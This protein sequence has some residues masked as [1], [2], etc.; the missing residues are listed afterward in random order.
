MGHSGDLEN[1]RTS[2]VSMKHTK[3]TFESLDNTEH[4]FC[5]MCGIID[6]HKTVT[7]PCPPWDSQ[8]RGDIKAKRVYEVEVV[9]QLKKM[10]AD[11]FDYISEETPP[12]EI[13]KY[14]FYLIDK[15]IQKLEDQAGE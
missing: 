5:V 2:G 11:L 7:M 13:I 6:T 1:Q 14:G 15:L 3:H 9:Q 12:G 4:G 8:G 10:R